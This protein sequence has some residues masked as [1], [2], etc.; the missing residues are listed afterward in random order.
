MREEAGNDEMF[1]EAAFGHDAGEQYG[2][3]CSARPPNGGPPLKC[4][5]ALWSGGWRDGSRSFWALTPRGITLTA[6]LR[7]VIVL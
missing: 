5:L 7:R 6:P 3:M 1:H 4:R 2:P